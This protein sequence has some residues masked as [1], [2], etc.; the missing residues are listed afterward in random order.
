MRTQPKLVAALA[1]VTLLVSGCGLNLYDVPLP[2]G[3]DT[4]ASPFRVKVQFADVLDLVPQSAVKVNDVPVGRVESVNLGPDGWSAEVTVVVNDGVKLP[5][6]ATAALKQSSLLGEK[7]IDLSTPVNE[8][9]AG[10]LHDGDVIT[11]D[12][13]SVV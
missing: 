10:S 12:R 4:G 3:A 7:F 2:G 1:S 8:A 6:N 11:R 9:P 13:K 5:G